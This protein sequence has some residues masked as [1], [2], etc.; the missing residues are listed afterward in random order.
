MLPQLI[1]FSDLLLKLEYDI[2]RYKKNNHTYELMDCLL[3]LNALPEWIIGSPNVESVLKTIAKEKIQIMKGVNF[4]F[5]EERLDFDLDTKLRFIRLICNHSKHKTD[6]IHIPIIKSKGAITLPAILPATFI[7][8][9]FIGNKQ[10]NAQKL[11]CD[12]YDFWKGAIN[13]N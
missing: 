6:S 5:D 3:T 1:D 4:G 13:A 10:I 12:V 11:I 7:S 9:I 2:D 8:M